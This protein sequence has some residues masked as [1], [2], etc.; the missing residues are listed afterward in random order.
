[1]SRPIV[2]RID[3]GA[4]EH[5]L[6][7]AR[8]FAGS[9]EV[10]AVVKANA[11]GHGLK[12]VWRALRAADG[13]AVLDLADAVS[14]RESGYEKRILLLEGFFSAD[15]LP[16]LVK[17]NLTPVVHS[18]E[19]LDI[20]QHAPAGAPLDVFL[21][22]NSG[23]NRLGFTME[24]APDAMR[25][26]RAMPSIQNVILMTHF[27][28]AEEAH[29]VEWQM[30]RV[31]PLLEATSARWS[32]ANSAALLRHP[33]TRGDFVRPGII[34]YGASPFQDQDANA[35]NLKPVMTLESAIIGVQ[36]LVAG[37]IVGYGGRFRADRP[38]RVGVVAAGY[39]DGYPRHAPDGTPVLV[40]GVRTRTVG[41]ISMDLL[42]VDLTDIPQAGMGSTVTLWGKGLPVDEVAAAAG[43]VSYELLCALAPRVPVVSHT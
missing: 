39:A 23:M 25:S 12:R 20:L 29:G 40:A 32:F 10:L 7:I 38:T 4:M 2:A 17:N 27:S 21:K 11:Y 34:L 15:E 24:R 3:L 35:L 1:V 14:L 26:L 37:D 8:S 18:A 6:S 42:C 30:A 22:V 9:A 19:Q 43:T 16:V 13:M 33:D 31:R 41:R 5:N 36:A 28:A